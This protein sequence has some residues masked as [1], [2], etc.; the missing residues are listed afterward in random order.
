MEK[1]LKLRNKILKALPKAVAAVTMTFQNPPFSPGRDHK[2]KSIVPMI[3]H[4]ARRKTHIDGIYSQEP[5]SPKISC[6]GQIKH[7]KKQIKQAK[8]TKSMNRRKEAKNVACNKSSSASRDPEVKKHASKFQKMILFN[9]AKPK[10]EGRK[11]NASA[12]GDISNRDHGLGEA[13]RAPHV[14]QMRRFSSGR[15]AL[16]GFDW[17]VAQVAP[18]EEEIDYY[19]DDYRVDSSDGEEEEEEVLIPFSAPI[20]VGGGGVGVLN[21]KPRKEINLWKRRT[22]APPMPLQLHGAN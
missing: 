4:E 7:K 2:S 1:Q 13:A 12:P 16:A 3:P 22:M 9:S 19:S 14:S 11:S 6:M 15:D 18:D 10:S 17:R 8:K 21:L 5:T 20:L